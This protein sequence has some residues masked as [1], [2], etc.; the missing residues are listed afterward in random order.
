MANDPFGGMDSPGYHEILERIAALEARLARIEKQA[1]QFERTA[2][3]VPQEPEKQPTR[4]I[5]TDDEMIH[6]DDAAI[7]SHVLEYGLALFG[8]VILALGIIFLSS[9]IQNHASAFF[10]SL[11]G[12]AAVAAVY[13]FAWTQKRSYPYLSFVF[14][15]LGYLLAFYVAAR[16]YFFTSPPVIPYKAVVLILMMAIVAV[17]V[18]RAIQIRSE[19]LALLALLFILAISIFA[20]SWQISLSAVVAVSLVSMLLMVKFEWKTQ[21]IL[22]I[23]LAYIA[24]LN[25]LL[26]NPLMPHT[27]IFVQVP[28][29]NLYFLFLTGAIYSSLPVARKSLQGNEVNQATLLLNGFGFSLVAGLIAL[30]FYSQHFTWI[31]LLVALFCLAY[32]VYLQIRFD[33]KFDSS[34]F[35]CFGFMATSI[36]VYGY[37]GLPGAYFLLAWQA[38]LVVSIALWY[39]SRIIILINFILF[40]FLILAYLLSS[41][42]PDRI[43]FSIP[44][45][46][47]ISAR[48]IN[49]QKERLSIKTDTIRNVYLIA[50]FFM[51]LFALYHALPVNLITISWTAAAFG[52]FLLSIILK[53]AKYRWMALGTLVASGL[54]L[55]FSDLKHME[56]GL[57]VVTFLFLAIISLGAAIYYSKRIKNRKQ[58]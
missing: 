1:T 19:F 36:A 24:H 30:R 58:V 48:I 40:L 15:V 34:V 47:I 26:G 10:S 27:T 12:F 7:E 23:F 46:A 52:Y 41:T 4:V 2:E 22:S 55:F 16:L 39:R 37:A 35:A 32:S 20:D 33:R 17:Q 54:H 53:N 21:L 9:L 49:W 44:V 45:V 57:R 56:T 50:A 8:S 42:M 18:Y 5:A 14:S 11:F 51:F 6:V 25:W 3:P 29:A 13:F 31:F 28:L 43:S 38:L